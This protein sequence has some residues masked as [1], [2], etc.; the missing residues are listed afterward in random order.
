[1]VVNRAAMQYRIQVDMLSAWSIIGWSSFLSVTP[2]SPSWSVAVS[3][4]PNHLKN[5]LPK[6]RS[7][8][9]QKPYCFHLALYEM[10]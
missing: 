7:A 9:E 6:K 8:C 10:R 2:I 3:T 5:D 1:M 4:G